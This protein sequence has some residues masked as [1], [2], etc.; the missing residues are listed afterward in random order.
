MFTRNGLAAEPV[1]YA[2]GCI[3]LW[4]MNRELDLSRGLAVLRVATVKRIAL[5]NPDHAPYGWAAKA[6]LVHEHLWD[7]TNPSNYLA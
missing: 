2:E 3:V 5:A 6:A 1:K 7:D 4:T